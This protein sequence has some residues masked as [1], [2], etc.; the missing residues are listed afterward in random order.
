[1][2][3]MRW[4]WL[5]V[6]RDWKTRIVAG[7]FFLFLATFSLLYRQQNL[8][9]PYLEMDAEYSEAQQIFRLIPDSHFE[10]EVGR[11][12]Q[13][14]LGETQTLTG[15]NRYLLSYQESE[16]GDFVQVV[17]GEYTE[18][19]KRIAENILFLHDETEFESHDILVENYLPSREEAEE[20]Y[21]FFEALE[22]RG[23][24]IEWNPYSSAEVLRAQIELVSGIVLFLLIALLSADHFTKEQL[25]NWSVTQG[26]PLPIKRQWRER[27]FYLWII[28]WASMLSGI[29]LSY[30]IS[31][32]FG[33]SGSL[34]YPIAYYINGERQYLSLWQYVLVLLALNMALSYILLLLGTGLSWM[35]KNIYL[36]I[37][38]V[39]IVFFLPM[40]GEWVP[41]F[42]SWQPVLYLNPLEVLIGETA[43]NVGISGVEF[44]KMPLVLLAIWLLLEWIFSKVFSLI[45]T[46]T[47]GLKR[48]VSHDT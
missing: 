30:G 48:R 42:T 15:M 7:C 19:G 25:N 1:M 43:R 3:Q 21:R 23:L 45:P 20:Q 4:N 5:K 40:I 10:G 12:V 11:E 22:E 34:R 8:V 39:V 38:L 47:M 29:V 6:S 33:T 24:P 32:L 41:L 46:K 27:S 35:I 18:N 9:L 16:A 17:T 31:L 28:T 14:R 36:T 37:L 13:Q 2:K 26:L 44:W